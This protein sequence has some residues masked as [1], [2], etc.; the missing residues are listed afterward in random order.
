MVAVIITLLTCFGLI[1]LVLFKP[2]LTVMHKNFATYWMISLIGA[3]LMIVFRQVDFKTIW[4][5]FTSQTAVNPVKILILFLSMTLLSICLDELGFFSYLANKLLQKLGNSQTKLFF[6]IYAMVSLL[7]IVT[8]NDIV[9]LTFTPFICYFSKKARINP[10]PYLIAEFIGA[11]TWSMFLIIGNPTNIYLATFYGIDFL[12]YIKT[13]FLPT[14][15]SGLLSCG[16]LYVLFRRSFQVPI[17]QETNEMIIENKPGLIVGIVHLVACIALLSISSYINLEMWII[18]LSLAVSLFV[19]SLIINLLT[20]KKNAYL[21][22]TLKRGPYELIPFVFSMFVIVLALNEQGISEK[23]ASFLTGNPVWQ[24]GITS[25]L[26]CNLINNIPMSVLFS[27]VLSYQNSI[28]AVYATII[29]S[30]LGALL[31]P[32]GALAGIMWLNL[33]KKQ[34]IPI[35]FYTFIFYCGIIS[36]PALMVALGILFVL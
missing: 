34:H 27:S 20:K 16:I 1:L 8:S 23:I 29:G 19:C 10:I 2:S 28:K 7:T 32:I 24:Y 33:L 5:G 36:V 31:T 21:L 12:S 35:H 25:Y 17:Y 11:N 22:S 18:A 6:G 30:N 26:S 4:E 15:A 13:M 3:I 14:I 9:I